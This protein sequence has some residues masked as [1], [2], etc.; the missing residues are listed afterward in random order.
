MIGAV[1]VEVD[2]FTGAREIRA[3]S[4]AETDSLGRGAAIFHAS[5]PSQRM[6]SAART[7]AGSGKRR[8]FPFSHINDAEIKMFNYIA[9]HMPEGA[10]GKISFLTMRS[11]LGGQV[12][13]PMPACSSCTAAFFE[14]AGDF[15]GVAIGSYAA[16]YPAAGEIDIG[17]EHPAASPEPEAPPTKT[18]RSV[19]KPDVPAARTSGSSSEPDVPTAK[20]IGPGA[21]PEIGPVVEATPAGQPRV[22]VPEIPPAG[23]KGPAPEDVPELP[24]ATGTAGT[25]GIALSAFSLGLI[26]LRFLPEPGAGK[27]IQDALAARLAEPRWQSRMKEVQHEAIA[28]PG[29]RYYSIEFKITYVASK[30]W[31]W[32]ADTMHR[33]ESVDLLSIKLSKEDLT[34][35]GK[36]DPPEKP[37]GLRLAQP[38]GEYTWKAT[39]PCVTSALVARPEIGPTYALEGDTEIREAVSAADDATLA[40]MPSSERERITRRLFKGWVSDDDLDTIVRVYKTAAADQKA[41]LKKVIEELIPTLW[42]IGQRTHLRVALAQP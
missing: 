42:S 4:G 28:T 35:C 26:L 34:H 5:T 11:R 12:I 2:G 22:E 10:T 1:I 9:S 8:E 27:P 21:D 16:V 36:L 19:D 38:M 25:G 3:I 20:T 30:H 31:H 14:L 33:F 24:A 40:R 39:C 41:R 37:E 29:V 18:E 6:F 32:R 7:I 15:P 13:E 23:T 17:D